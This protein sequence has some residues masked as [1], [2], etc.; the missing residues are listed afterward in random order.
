MATEIIPNISSPH[1]ETQSRRMRLKHHWGPQRQ[2]RT[3]SKGKRRGCILTASPLTQVAQHC[4]KRVPRGLLFLHWRE[5]RAR[6]TPSSPSTIGH[7]LGGL[8]HSCL[9]GITGEICRGS[10]KDGKGGGAYRNQY[11]DLILGASHSYLQQW[12]PG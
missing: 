2:R 7:F 9:M 6:Q 11:S 10:N 4:T 5:E 12:D 8:F 1:K 3:T